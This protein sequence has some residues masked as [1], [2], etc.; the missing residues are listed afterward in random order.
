MVSMTAYFSKT[1][2][3]NSDFCNKNKKRLYY[4]FKNSVI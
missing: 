3:A 2:V 4:T 1:K